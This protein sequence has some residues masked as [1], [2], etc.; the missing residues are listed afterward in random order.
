V[1]ASDDSTGTDNTLAIGSQ[2]SSGRDL[3]ARRRNMSRVSLD[4][5]GVFVHGFD[6]KHGAGAYFSL[7]RKFSSLL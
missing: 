2:Q 3:P 7:L 4:R 6:A 5:S 1:V